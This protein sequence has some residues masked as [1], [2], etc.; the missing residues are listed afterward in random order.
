MLVRLFNQIFVDE[1]DIYLLVFA[2]ILLV[3]L[4]IPAALL[5]ALIPL[6]PF[7]KGSLL[8]LLLF[9][10]IS[11]FRLSNDVNKTS[12]MFWVS[13]SGLVGAFFLSPYGLAFYLLIISLLPVR[14]RR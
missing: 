8:V 2:L 3:L 11:R 13:V 9:L 1:S 10:L 6:I 14:A 4:L 12:A 5:T 7:N